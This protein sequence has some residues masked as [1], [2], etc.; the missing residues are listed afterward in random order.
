MSNEH[1][2]LSEFTSFRAEMREHMN[3]QT[4]LMKQM[5]ELQ[6]KHSHLELQLSRNEAK[7]DGL[8][9]RLRPV[10]AQ[11]QSTLERTKYNRDIAWLV[12]TILVGIGTFSIRTLLNS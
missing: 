8:E 6:T 7:L 9:A 4:Q 10:E 3:Q 5:V 11:Q 12:L 1:V 2:P